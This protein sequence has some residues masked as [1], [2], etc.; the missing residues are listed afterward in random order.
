MRR[1]FCLAILLFV[2][3]SIT[4][5]E[6]APEKVTPI[7]YYDNTYYLIE[8]SNIADSLKEN[9]FDRLPLSYKDK[10]REP[11]W[12]LS[13][14]SAGL[15][16]R[17]RSN[18]TIIKAKWKLL[19]DNAMN[20]MASTGIKGMDL[21][22][23]VGRDWQYINTARPVGVEN[24]SL[25]IENMTAEWREY[26]LFLPLYDGVSNV[27]I[28][29]DSLSEIS[30]PVKSD[31]KPIVFYGTSITQGGC[32][33]RPGMAYPSIISR[34][35]DLDCINLG[36]SGNGRMEAPIVEIMADIDALIYVIDCLPNM[37]AGQVLENTVLLVAGLRR[38]HPS[39]P[40][41]FIENPVYEKAFFDIKERRIVDEKNATLK[42]EVDKVIASGDS[43]I[44]YIDNRFSVEQDHEGTVDNVHLTDLGFMRFAD[45]LIAKFEE[46]QLLPR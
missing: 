29:I 43:N 21:Y 28:G 15:S 17:F 39:T 11:V 25:L 35:L 38:A 44:Y 7:Q 45:Y 20:H 18:S 26:R 27:E 30:M 36:F 10:V 16:V 31:R 24:E 2:S 19:F 46:F 1:F 5:Q 33:S 22:C 8:G 4:A 42:I 6:I 23:R 40:I 41:V 13:K 14:N 32:A 34:K 9:L 12:N 3:R 37:K